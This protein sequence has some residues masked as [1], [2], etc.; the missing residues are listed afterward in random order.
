MCLSDLYINYALSFQF[1][2]GDKVKVDT[3]YEKAKQLQVNH[4]GWN[5][6]MKGVCKDILIKKFLYC[7]QFSR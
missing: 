6:K 3:D 4:G 1:A 2:E 5:D 7:T